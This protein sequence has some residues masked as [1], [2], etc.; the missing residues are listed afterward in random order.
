MK[1]LIFVLPVFLVLM[2]CPKDEPVV[3]LIPAEPTI[4][5]R[6]KYISLVYYENNVLL[7]SEIVEHIA[8]C[9]TLF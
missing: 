6:W 2:G 7:D 1:R 3:D 5:G 9:P 8:D 4:V